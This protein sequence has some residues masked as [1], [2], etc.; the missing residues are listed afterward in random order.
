[1]KP[2]SLEGPRFC[3]QFLNHVL[4]P[5]HGCG[6]PAVSSAAR[7]L[8]EVAVDLHR[9]VK[10]TEDVDLLVDGLEVDDSVVPP[11]QDAR[12]RPRLRPIALAQSWKVLQDLSPGVDRL[13]D[14]E[15]GCRL[16]LGDVVVGY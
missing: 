13:D 16:V 4:P 12:A 5:G 11:K 10:D 9:S 2:T 6:S 14:F 3:L 15:R 7:C 1:M 8:F